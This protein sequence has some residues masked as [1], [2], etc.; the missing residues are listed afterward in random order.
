MQICK[1]IKGDF[2]EEVV[3]RQKM[4]NVCLRVSQLKQVGG[5]IGRTMY[6]R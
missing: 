6:S 1:I 3:A 5:G 2:L 4:N